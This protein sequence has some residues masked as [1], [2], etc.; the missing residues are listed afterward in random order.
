MLKLKRLI[1]ALLSVVFAFAIFTAACKVEQKA[2]IDQ[3]ALVGITLDT[4]RAKKTYEIGENFSTENLVVKATMKDIDSGLETQK[5]V[6][7]SAKVDSTLYDSSKVGAYRIYV[8]YTHAGVTRS[9]SYEVKVNLAEPKFGGITVE[10]VAGF[11]DTK[12]LTV[13]M[14][15]VTIEP[16]L[17][18]K[19][20]GED[21]TVGETLSA[22]EYDVKLYLGSVEQSSWTVRGGAYTIV[23]SLKSDPKIKNFV[24]YYVVDSLNSLSWNSTAAGTV[25]QI[26]QWSSDYAV[27]QM[28]LTWS[29]TAMYK[30]AG[31]KTL[32]I[33]DEGVSYKC[34]VETDG[35][36]TVAVT[37]TERNALGVQET[38]TTS[39]TINVSKYDGDINEY[40]YN[41]DELVGVLQGL[42]LS[43]NDKTQLI[44][45]YF[46][47]TSNS[48]LKFIEKDSTSADQYRTSN[49]NPSCIEIKGGRLQVTFEGKGYIEIGFS[50]N[51]GTS[52]SGLVL[53]DYN[54]EYVYGTIQGN[55]SNIVELI[56]DDEDGNLKGLFVVTGTSERK[57][58]FS[59]EGPGTYTIYS[60]YNF[61]TQ[62]RG[63]RLYSI[64]MIDVVAK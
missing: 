33:A 8:S 60:W 24:N 53:V 1:P 59:V 17:V 5:D 57:V 44:A 48:F 13:S 27:K 45:D 55:T 40:N 4:S 42:S 54:N 64:K 56:E 28:A 23:V 21:G 58:K 29:F 19:K 63:S 10:Y 30:S 6:S 62:S 35:T 61:G 36:Q 43:G 7:T 32:T 46:N 3:N 15:Q 20:I 18:V 9:D 47:T 41:F 50:S 2:G 12:T 22:S 51:G 31:S 38:K 14:P 37:F 16:Q 49:G 52:Q 34:N 25:T 11:E 26:E 39:V